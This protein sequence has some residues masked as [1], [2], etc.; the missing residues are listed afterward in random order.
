LLS[1]GPFHPND[2]THKANKSFKSPDIS[3][4]FSNGQLTFSTNGIDTFPAPSAYLSRRHSW[5]HIFP[6]GKVHQQED[7]TMR[8]FK[9]GVSRLILESEPCPD[10][11][12]MWIEGPQEV[13]HES[14]E[15][16]RFLPRPLRNVSITFGDKLDVEKVFGDLRERWKRLHQRELEGGSEGPLEMGVLTHALKYAEEAVE[17]R[18]ECTLRVRNAVLRVRRQRGWPDEDPKA[19][20]VDT[21]REEGTD[22]VEG[23]MKDG[24]W[25]KDT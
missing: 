9:W 25:V 15:F 13:M 11:V 18:K 24:S 6:E 19:S 10:V 22:K 16:P 3:D 4:P 20:L 2:H 12:P 1:S 17:L 7:R 21:Y 14:R 8:Y 23:K 5:V